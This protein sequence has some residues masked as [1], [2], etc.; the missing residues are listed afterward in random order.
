MLTG[1][2][3]HYSRLVDVRNHRHCRLSALTQ[4]EILSSM[5]CT[6]SALSTAAAAI[7]RCAV[8]FS[9]SRCSIVF[10]AQCTLVQSAILPSHVFR[11]S[12]TL[13]VC[14]HIGWKSWKIVVRA[15]SP[16]SSLFVAKMRSTYS[17]ANIGKFWRTN[18]A[19][20]LKRV[21]IEEKLL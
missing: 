12:V 13:V 21:K 15:I 16:T 6:M 19:I 7:P 14:D 20:S 4:L 11:L 17:Q 8:Y 18:A 5:L 2:R 10:T 3:L 1:C 9:L